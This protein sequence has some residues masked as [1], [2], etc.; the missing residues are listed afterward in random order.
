LQSLP[1]AFVLYTPRRPPS[2]SEENDDTLVG[3]GKRS[4][5]DLRSMK[6]LVERSTLANISKGMSGEEKALPRENRLGEYEVL[7]EIGRGGFGVVYVA[8]DPKLER[9]VAIKV[10]SPHLAIQSG[11][12]ER[13]ER[14][15]TSAGRL[16]HPNIVSVYTT[17]EDNGL[18]YIV[19]EYV[20]GKTLD[21][22]TRYRVPALEESVGVIEKVA[23][24]LDYAHE[25]GIIHRDL[26]P[27]NVMLETRTNRI[28]I[29]DFGLA[30][31]E[32]PGS[33]LTESD[34]LV[35][36]PAYM[37]PEQA[38]S[39]LEKVD[40]RSDIFS[41]G[42][43]LY[44]L[45]TGKLPFEGSTPVE[46]LR[47]V[48]EEDPVPPS[49]LK[50]GIPRD[51]EAVV[52]KSLE[53][54]PSKR[55]QTAKDLAEDLARYRT[56][57]SVLAKKRTLVG[58]SIRWAGR[59][60]RLLSGL[61]VGGVLVASIVGTLAWRRI[62]RE[63]EVARRLEKDAQAAALQAEAKIAKFEEEVEGD[64][65]KK[66]FFSDT[67][68]AAELGEAWELEGDIEGWNVR[69][70]A[71]EYFGHSG[72]VAWIGDPIVGDFRLEFEI[73][74]PEW[75]EA[76]LDKASRIHM[77]RN[78]LAPPSEPLVP[79]REDW[80]DFSPVRSGTDRVC[81]LKLRDVFYL[82]ATYA[83][84]ALQDSAGQAWRVHLGGVG[85]QNPRSTVPGKNVKSITS[86]SLARGTPWHGKAETLVCESD[87][88]CDI[89]S[90]SV[91]LIREG[92]LFSVLVEG[93]E[94][95]KGAVPGRMLRVGLVA[96]RTAQDW[97]MAYWIP[98]DQVCDVYT[99][100]RF[101]S[102]RIFRKRMATRASPLAL[103]ERYLASN[104]YAFA[105][106]M[107][108]RILEEGLPDS[109]V[110]KAHAELAQAL[111]GQDRIEDAIGHLVTARDS[112][113]DEI[114]SLCRAVALI[115]DKGRELVPSDFFDQSQLPLAWEIFV[116]WGDDEEA[117]EISMQ[118]TQRHAEAVVSALTD[119][120][121]VLAEA[122]LD[123]AVRLPRETVLPHLV[124]FGRSA[125]DE[126]SAGMRRLLR[127][128]LASPERRDLISDT[129]AQLDRER[130]MRGSI[131]LLSDPEEEVS[132]NAA[133]ALGEVGGPKGVQALA[134]V[135]LS[136]EYRPGPRRQAAE[137][138]GKLEA[139]DILLEKTLDPKRVTR[140]RALE[141]LGYAG[142]AKAIPFLLSR[143]EEDQEVL[144][145]IAKAL[146][147]LDAEQAAP[148]LLDL[149]ESEESW[150]R[151]Q[152][153][154]ALVRMET[155]E[156][157]SHVPPMLDD[158]DAKVRNAA[159]VALEHFR[160][161]DQIP[162][163]TELLKDPDPK[164]RENASRCLASL[165]RPEDQSV[166]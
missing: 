31:P 22:Y 81:G 36:T 154:V 145:S 40:R 24:G 82:L 48:S 89:D 139:T 53:K 43:V 72:G 110:G 70:N 4:L 61:T 116:V 67:F 155:P 58:E 136:G 12:V 84:I 148:I 17:G 140:A 29:M 9:Q 71:L 161:N 21:D 165:S 120:R 90:Y 75:D 164:V 143:I 147:L 11:Y 32:Q 19:M 157:A 33:T 79:N 149:L 35:G 166:P 103:P 83:E 122:G 108:Q 142:D 2:L 78:G 54:T 163:V 10:L 96:Y 27:S 52:L 65:A 134:E 113:V 59:N 38:Q 115:R 23:Q 121:A 118:L 28:V 109:L 92:E 3:K 117:E 125:L 152:A 5:A 26:K 95:L 42:V 153:L 66:P 128:D 8:R 137:S 124:R 41:L 62:E 50:R 119:D 20:E 49:K 162:K 45:L 158:P 44:E 102:V 106:E 74:L 98:G 63:R 111:A 14:E 133:W 146:G 99:W 57:Q 129:L 159:L 88:S 15:A 86:V 60:R 6:D 69:E 104:E 130:I 100:H 94:V 55:Y 80:S 97:H 156:V 25:A 87:F 37:S 132:K 30:R 1:R 141:A 101:G 46:I 135:V 47:K 18:H 7:R 51:L 73:E 107:L 16:R 160:M 144:S 34:V 126:P 138:L 77:R 68:A 151:Y 56:G 114:E 76:R 39:S 131:D 91:V 85:V 127:L 13:F 64:W 105:E 93:E 150:V 112:G 123:V